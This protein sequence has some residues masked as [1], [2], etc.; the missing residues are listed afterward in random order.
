MLFKDRR[1]ATLHKSGLTLLLLSF[2][3]RDSFIG[4]GITQAIESRA[5][6]ASSL[7]CKTMTGSTGYMMLCVK[8]VGY[9]SLTPKDFAFAILDSLCKA[10]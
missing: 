8:R 3:Y 4:A 6:A 5:L 10:G 2:L 1:I 9:L 7:W